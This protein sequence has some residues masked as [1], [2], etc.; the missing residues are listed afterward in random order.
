MFTYTVIY[1]PYI[2]EFSLGKFMDS[3]NLL[4]YNLVH[5]IYHC[6]VTFHSPKAMR[7]SQSHAVIILGMGPTNDRWRYIITRS[8]IGL[9]HAQN[10]PGPMTFVYLYS[11]LKCSIEIFPKI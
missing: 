5:M 6:N 10:D 4:N 9:A 3:L 8:L 1:T 11:L 7:K 2:S